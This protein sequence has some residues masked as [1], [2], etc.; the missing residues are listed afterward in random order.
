MDTPER[1]RQLIYEAVK[2]LEAY[3]KA[4]ETAAEETY[5]AQYSYFCGLRK[6]LQ[7]LGYRKELESA[8]HTADE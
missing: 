8:I 1:V 2:A 6:A 5:E 3:E 4:R 7:I